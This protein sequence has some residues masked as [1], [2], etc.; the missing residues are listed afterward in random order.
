MVG[1]ESGS[2]VNHP[3]APSLMR[4]GIPEPS[5][6]RRRESSPLS[7]DLD[8]PPFDKLRASSTRG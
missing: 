1:T 6:P 4:R 5:F 7:T 8:P 2:R 3:L